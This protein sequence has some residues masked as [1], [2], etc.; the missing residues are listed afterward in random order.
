MAHTETYIDPNEGF[1]LDRLAQVTGN[2]MWDV[3]YQCMDARP[4]FEFYNSGLN[5]R[6]YTTV[7]P[8]RC[9]T[10]RNV[11]VYEKTTV[12]HDGESYVAMSYIGPGVQPGTYLA[13]TSA[14]HAYTRGILNV[15]MFALNK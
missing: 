11:L 14:D 12:V 9:P 15:R 10:A 7:H 1:L 4:Y 3:G 6:W 5:E 8:N 13:P 2:P